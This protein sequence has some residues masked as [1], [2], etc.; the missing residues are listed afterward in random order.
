MFVSGVTAPKLVNHKRIHSP[1]DIIADI[2]EFYGVQISYQQAWHAKERALEM[3]RGKPSAGYRQMSRYIYMLNTV[4]PNS[5]IRMQKTEEDEFMYLFVAL[6]PLIRGST[7]RPIVVVDGAHLDGAYKGT[8]VSTST[9]DGHVVPSSEFIFS[10]YEAG[11][12]YICLERK[13]CS[14]GRFHLDEIPCTHA[15]VVLKE[16]NVKDMHQYCSDYYKPD[17]LAK[18]YEIPMVP[19]PDKEDWSP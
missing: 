18:T 1:K 14:Y 4:Y 12:K 11:R 13:V 9:L 7:R 3:I 2:R 19:I 6:R 15:I 16:K 5:Y 17:A 10:V 8:F